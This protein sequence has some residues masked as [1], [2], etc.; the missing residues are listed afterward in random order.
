MKIASVWR[1]FLMIVDDDGASVPTP[2]CI[3]TLVITTRRFIITQPALI[4]NCPRYEGAS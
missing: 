3:S 1:L 4:I 2:F